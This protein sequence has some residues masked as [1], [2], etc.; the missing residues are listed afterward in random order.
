[1]KLCLNKQL[2][3]KQRSTVVVEWVLLPK[4]DFNKLWE[5][6]CKIFVT[7]QISNES[8]YNLNIF[9]IFLE[10]CCNTWLHLICFCSENLIAL[11]KTEVKLKWMEV[12]ERNLFWRYFKDLSL[13]SVLFEGGFYRFVLVT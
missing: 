7:P 13:I 5:S 9:Q 11:D 2:N 4:I 12:F 10:Y 8:V 1:M 3:L 6:L